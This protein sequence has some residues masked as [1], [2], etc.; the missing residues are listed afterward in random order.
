MCCRMVPDASTIY[1]HTESFLYKYFQGD[2]LTDFINLFSIRYE[3]VK[4][5]YYRKDISISGE[6]KLVFWSV[7]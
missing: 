3:L 7:R 2:N 1:N 6:A 4:D 5:T